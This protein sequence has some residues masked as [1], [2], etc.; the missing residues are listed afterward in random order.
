MS[1]A[2]L[3]PRGRI[4]LLL[5]WGLGIWLALAA[6]GRAGEAPAAPAVPAA[7]APAAAPAAPGQATPAVPTK[8]NLTWFFESAGLIG[9]LLGR[10]LRK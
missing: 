5:L 9:F 3:G 2:H 1:R 10:W 8:S 4:S 6:T 7:E